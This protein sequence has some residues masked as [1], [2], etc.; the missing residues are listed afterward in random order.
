MN[1]T[2]LVVLI[3][4]GSV[5]VAEAKRGLGPALFTVA[6]AFVSANLA[7]LW[8]GPVS[9][10][11]HLT[12][13]AGHNQ[14]WVLGIIFAL[15]MAVVLTVTHVLHPETFLSADPFD[16]P[17][18]AVCGFFTGCIACWVLYKGV[19]IWGAK[20]VIRASLF[21]PEILEARTYHNIVRG[22]YHL[23]EVQE[24]RLDVK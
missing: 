5:T 15:L 23:G 10:S 20:D 13:P 16:G 6:G 3:I 9:R 2:D 12:T 4:V 11:V 21:A 7:L 14:T 17:L 18:G 22:M 19:G 1:W 8:S 24:K